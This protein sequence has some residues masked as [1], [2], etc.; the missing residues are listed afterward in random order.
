MKN[1]NAII[2]FSF[3]LIFISVFCSVKAQ[4]VADTSAIPI[5][6]SLN[7]I[8]AYLLGIG[9]EREQKFT[10]SS[11]LYFGAA[12]ESVVPYFPRRPEGASDVL[13]LDQSF[14]FAPLLSIGFR[15]YYNLSDILK[16]GKSIKNNAGNFVGLEYNLIMPVLITN[17]STTTSFS[18]LSPIWGFQRSISK[19]KNIE[20]A[21]GPSLQTDFKR[22]RISGLVRFGF[23]FLL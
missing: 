23:N 8:K 13:G 4:E 16:K 3:S 10:K 1:R 9:L 18:S 22:Y 7:K 12:I 2:T 17:K 11:T 6:K 14:N 21:F 19:N 5:P 20:L 15:N